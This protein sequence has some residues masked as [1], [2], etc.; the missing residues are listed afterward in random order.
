V[1]SGA[2]ILEAL[3]RVEP[4]VYLRGEVAATLSLLYEGSVGAAGGGE[5]GPAGVLR[6]RRVLHSLAVRYGLSH[7][8][9]TPQTFR[10]A[11]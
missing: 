8:G 6:A 7:L 10:L 9:A 11:A 2:A 4:A 1:A 3:V 5:G